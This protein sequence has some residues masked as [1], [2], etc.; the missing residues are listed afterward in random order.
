ML[1][2]MRLGVRLAVAFAIIVG[3]MLIMMAEALATSSSQHTATDRME[4]AQQF[5]ATVKDAKFSAADF[6][7]WQTAYAFDA[8]RDVADAAADTGSSRKA[9]LASVDTFR[10][11]TE[12]AAGLAPT[13]AAQDALQRIGGLVDEFMTVDAEIARLYTAG[14]DRA[15]ND[16]VLGRE[17]ELFEE[18]GDLLDQAAATA[19]SAFAAAK[20]DAADAHTSGTRTTWAVGIGAVVLAVILAAMV[21]LSV[22]RPVER[23]RQRLELLADGDLATPVEVTGRDEVA[24]MAGALGRSLVSLGNV[25]RTIDDSATALATATEQM[26]AASTEIAASAE[27]SAVQAQAVADAANQVSNN[28]QAVSAGSEQMGASI[29]EIAHST[30]EAA[31]VAV[32]AVQAAEAAN[33]TVASLGESSREISEVVKVI[34]SI[35]EQTNLLALN[36]TI[37]SA[38]AGEAGKGFAVV[39]GEVKELAQETARATEDIIRRVD[40][41]QS[42]TTSAVAAI[43]EIAAVI[44]R[45]S[46]YQTTIS[47]AVEEQTA[48]TAEMNRS[49]SDTAQAADAIAVNVST[50]AEAAQHTTHGV[51][52]AQQATAELAGMSAGLRTLVSH[53]RY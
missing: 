32:T 16:L 46:D 28:V 38:R 42:G 1:T 11:R 12:A 10:T 35:A 29:R 36:A 30:S 15:A 49:V 47:A 3:L 50:V 19:D 24:E 25:M 45:V 17:I 34:T 51:T 21:T 18:I 26:S 41:I 23:I 13:G 31:A 33:T 7:G 52:E 9:F 53:F 40:A 14:R 22:T 8:L 4:R 43:G 2:R 39:A 6:N 5:V 37:E 20:L 27:E 48:T 44:R